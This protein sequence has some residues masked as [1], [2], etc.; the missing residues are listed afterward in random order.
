MRVATLCVAAGSRLE[1]VAFGKKAM[2][3]ASVGRR[4]FLIICSFMLSVIP[5][6]PSQTYFS[7][8]VMP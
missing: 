5:I 6:P 4:L 2:A 1:E 3:I 7:D 8:W